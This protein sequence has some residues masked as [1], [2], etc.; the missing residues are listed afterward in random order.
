MATLYR[1]A[2]VYDERWG[3]ENMLDSSFRCKQTFENLFILT[4]K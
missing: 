1:K 4:E 2:V 3:V